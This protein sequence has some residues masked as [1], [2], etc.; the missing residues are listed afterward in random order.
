[1]QFIASSLSEPEVAAVANYLASLPVT[2]ARPLKEPAVRL[3]LACGSQP[4]E[5]E[6]AR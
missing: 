3:P 6:A 2:T 4:F 5:L 1:M